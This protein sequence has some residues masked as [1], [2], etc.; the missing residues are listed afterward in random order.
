MKVIVFEVAGRSFALPAASVRGVAAV[1]P[2]TPLPFVPPFVEGLAAIGGRI[3]PQ[4]ALGLRLGLPAVPPG[5]AMA[6]DGAGELVV[7]GTAAGDIALRV[8]RV[9]HMAVIADDRLHA[10]AEQAIVGSDDSV[11][12]EFQWQ[13]RPVILLRAEALGLDGVEAVALPEGGDTALGVIEQR[14]RA[15]D[16]DVD[17]LAGLVVETAGGERYA[18]P[19]GQVAEVYEDGD[20]TNLPNAP[21]EVCGLSVLRGQ[22]R[23][24]LSLARLLG[25]TAADHGTRMVMITVRETTLVLRV[26]RLLG[27]RRFAHSRRQPVVDA[28][29]E[30]D[31][32]LIGEDG[33]VAGLLALDRLIDDAVLA[34]CRRY[35]PQIHEAGCRA[36]AVVRRVLVFQV[37]FET[38]ALDVGRIERI[39]NYV[40]FADLPAHGGQGLAGA[41]DIGGQVLP[42][43]DLAV[44]L[45]AVPPGVVGGSSRVPVPGA[46]AYIIARGQPGE[47]G[48]PRP[49]ALLVDRV[50]R[51]V[52]LPA[53][54]ITATAITAGAGA[55]A[56]GAAGQLAAE[57]GRL[58]GRLLSIL[59]PDALEAATLAGIP[60]AAAPVPLLAAE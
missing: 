49:W 48:A 3:L 55:G 26:D 1:V 29:S 22:P 42:V 19:L 14:R 27:I 47:D 9:R 52:N 18:L 35:L 21:A 58:D 2:V 38:C 13:D 6:A 25:G 40:P 30:L 39:A 56:A 34:R 36:A 8:D 17:T 32:Y 50:E 24:V 60:P 16:D 15:G 57:I 43:A 33:K 23:L 7:V 54:A 59:N 51:L 41:V 53:T 10:V 46:T 37:G 44:L 11:A 5:D 20:L 4:V 28:G 45:G 31:S 12:G